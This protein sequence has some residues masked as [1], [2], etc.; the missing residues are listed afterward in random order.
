[1]HRI[2]SA[3]LQGP[4]PQPSQF[5]PARILGTNPDTTVRASTRP[6]A[7]QNSSLI[8][9][10]PS[11]HS[12]AAGAARPYTDPGTLGADLLEEHVDAPKPR[13]NGLARA[14]RVGGSPA[15]PHSDH[16][17]DGASPW[18][19]SAIGPASSPVT[20]TRPRVVVIGAGFGGLNAVHALA[21]V[22]VDLVLIDRN[23]HH[24]FQ[25]LLYQVA[26][27]ALAPSDIASPIR[28]IFARQ[29]NVE[30]LLGEVDGIDIAARRVSVRE[31][32]AI[33]YNY[34]VLATGATS[35]W[36]GHADWAEHS[37]G[38]K[39]LEDAEALKSRLLGA[40]E[41]AESRTDPD[42]IR[43]LLT[44]VVVGGGATGVELAG[45]IREL[46]SATLARDFRR[47]RPD[48]ARVL[49]FEGGPD[50]LAGFPDRLIRYARARLERLG[51]EV[52]T[53]SQVEQVDEGGVVAGGQR[54]GSANVFWCAGVAATPAAQWIGAATGKHGTVRVGADCTVPGHPEIFAIGDVSSLDGADHRPLPGVAPV[55]KQQ[56]RYVAG[57]I[58]ARTAG[59]TAPGPF[60]YKDR[61]RLAIIGRSAAVANLPRVRLTGF[62][63][64]LLWSCVHLVLLNGLRNRVLVYVQWLWAWLFYARGARVMITSGLLRVGQSGPH[65]PGTEPLP[66]A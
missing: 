42:E 46:A 56:G 11:A 25:P 63:A 6:T 22:P 21:D 65:A 30:V 26:T 64:W 3:P 34:L 17:G 29:R 35:S 49:L 39:S 2:R 62:P 43:R 16:A 9:S 44:F 48:Q 40:F 31:L 12:L 53:G 4:V 33:P 45:S 10:I 18:S 58:A 28:A 1:M 13:S 5:T 38:L 23:N 14:G 57:A 7:G 37:V 36:F 54:I 47:I 55:A 24:L 52:H 60:R 51:V 19:M 32:G 15:D 8:L 20:A 50:V 41:W 59:G 27:A 66:P 61:G